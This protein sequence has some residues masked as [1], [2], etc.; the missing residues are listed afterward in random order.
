MTAREKALKALNDHPDG[1]SKSRL[2][3]IVGGNPGAFRRLVQ[4]MEDKNE[5]TI[6]EEDNPNWGPTKIVR[7]AA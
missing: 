6:T 7:A 1:L 2:R 4:S 3:E 5:I